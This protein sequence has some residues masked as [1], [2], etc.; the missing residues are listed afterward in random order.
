MQAPPIETNTETDIA[1]DSDALNAEIAEL[2]E[3]IQESNRT[4]EF[5]AAKARNTD[6]APVAQVEDDEPDVLDAITSGGAKGFDALAK[7]RGFVQRDEVES[8]I[9][10][11]ASALTTEQM[12]MTEYPDLK[13]KK[14]DF[15]KETAVHYR[16]L[17]QKGVPQVEAMQLAADKAQ[18]EG[19]RS[20]KIKSPGE[21]TKA[22]KEA[23]RLARV[24]AQ[25]DPVSGRRPAAPTEEDQTLSLEQ[26]HI[27]AAMGIS[28][29][30][31][32]KRAN[33]GVNLRSR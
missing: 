31:Y 3:Q 4:A 14:S 29:E 26:K 19:L 5:W 10:Q 15:F 18:L 25:S 8:L 13:D 1:P 12:L 22:D 17:V 32:S 30:A 16:T 9:N 33:A 11:R 23:T 7:K 28:E 21:Q 24:A 2:R 27:A 20:G 6:A